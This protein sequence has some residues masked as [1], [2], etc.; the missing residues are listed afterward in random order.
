[1]Y[2]LQKKS[3]KTN[4]QAIFTIYEEGVAYQKMLKGKCVKS[5]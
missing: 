1:M 5:W 4:S 3:A 2:F